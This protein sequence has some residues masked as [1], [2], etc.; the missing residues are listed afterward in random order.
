M[1]VKVTRTFVDKYTLKDIPKGE[2]LDITK[3]RFLELT[4][5][6]LGVFVEEI[7]SPKRKTT[8]KVGD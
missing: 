6:P 2:T 3:E 5:G 1:K 8:K 7:Q 4:E